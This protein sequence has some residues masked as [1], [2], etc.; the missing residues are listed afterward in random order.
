MNQKD[1]EGTKLVTKRTR[2]DEIRGHETKG[3]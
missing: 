2:G 1:L 3:L